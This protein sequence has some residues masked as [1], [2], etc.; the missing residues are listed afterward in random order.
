MVQ[1]QPAVEVVSEVDPELKSLLGDGED[2]AGFAHLLVLLGAPDLGGVDLREDPLRRDSQKFVPDWTDT[3]ELTGGGPA[4]DCA[5][6]GIVQQVNSALVPVDRE[7]IVGDVAIVDTVGA[8]SLSLRPLRPVREV[9]RQ[10]VSKR[11]VSHFW[12]P[13]T[14]NIPTSTAFSPGRGQLRLRLGAD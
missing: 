10:P 14:K 13:P 12:R 6:A 9:L 8:Q 2:L 1:E 4:L 7:W 5:A 11:G 3:L